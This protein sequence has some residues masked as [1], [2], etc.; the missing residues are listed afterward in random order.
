M[1]FREFT[2]GRTF[3][4]RLP[5]GSDLRESIQEFIREQGVRAGFVSAIGA[6][7]RACYSFYDAQKQVYEQ[8]AK[9]E[10]LEILGLT[11]NISLLDGAPFLHAHVIFGDRSGMA[12]GGHIEAGCVVFAGEVLIQE[13]TGPALERGAKDPQTALRLWA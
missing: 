10:E 7:S 1:F 13:V 9:E 2:Q 11:G 8:I 3:L 4:V 12:F 6:V 5:H